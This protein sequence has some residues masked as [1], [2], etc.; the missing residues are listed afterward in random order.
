MYRILSLDGGGVR[1]AFITAC[2]DRFQQKLKKPLVDY[3][4]LIIGT[5]AGG[6]IATLLC[7]EHST[8][9]IA[10][11]YK[12]RLSEIFLKNSQHSV[13]KTTNSIRSNNFL[14]LFLD[15]KSQQL[16]PPLYSDIGLK[17]LGKELVDD[18][19]M[20]S[21]S[22]HS[23]ILTTVDLKRGLPQLLSTPDLPQC[24]LEG[25]YPAVDAMLAT[26]AAPLYFPVA[27]IN[28][29]GLFGDGGLWAK[30][31]SM[32]GVSN[33]IELRQARQATPSSSLNVKDIQILSLGTGYCLESLYPNHQAIANPLTMA[34]FAMIFASC[35]QTKSSAL[36]L[37]QLLGRHFYRIDFAWPDDSWQLPD[38]LDIIPQLI[39]MGAESAE[40]H[41]TQ[42]SPLFFQS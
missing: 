39:T 32:L 20:A 26:S 19:T 24:Y 15:P 14:S 2:L 10:A 23:L 29:E 13:P 21:I 5:S 8:S 28:N 16:L 4:D 6:V 12:N 3:F 31:P 27:Q 42:V 7:F 36:Y 33:A 1:G 35:S 22:N 41:F 11:V 37:Q 25:Q 38:R 9:E 17:N 30:D 40:S 18:K 34:A